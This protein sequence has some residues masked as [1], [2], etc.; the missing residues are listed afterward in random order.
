[1]RDPGVGLWSRRGFRS[2]QAVSGRRLALRVLTFSHDSVGLGHFR[3][4]TNLARSFV[5]ADVDTSV[6]CL[7]GSPRPELFDLPAGVDQVKLPSIG[8]SKTG[9]YQSQRLHVATA[10]IISLRA[11]LIRV[12]AQQYRPDL[13]LVDHSPIGIGGELI[14]MLEEQ[15][16]AGRALIVLG[17]RDIVDEPQRARAELARQHTRHAMSNLYHRI[18]VY[19]HPHLCDQSLEYG[20]GLPVGRKLRYVGI[21]CDAPK[22]RSTEPGEGV[23]VTV[24]GGEDGLPA[25]RAAIDWLEHDPKTAQSATL[26]TGPLL[27]ADVRKAVNRRATAA[28]VTV[29]ESTSRLTELVDAAHTVVG[30]GGYNTV[31]ESLARRKRVVVIPRS[32]PRREQ[33]DRAHRLR[34]LGLLTVVEPDDLGRPGAVAAAVQRAQDARVVDPA[35]VGFRFDGATVAAE[36]LLGEASER[37]LAL[38]S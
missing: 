12:T 29:I 34:A 10:E 26:V 16:R 36:T 15:R 20:L 25:L 21:A 18:M 28:G 8:K 19:G 35:D 7:T 9:R 38:A 1:M 24:G 2:G 32:F 5:A 37:A 14:P 6:L 17:M 33:L 30:M 31:Y 11:E 23:L 3:R 27:Q 22:T 4:T 13:I